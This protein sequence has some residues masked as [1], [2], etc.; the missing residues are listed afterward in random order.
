MTGAVARARTVLSRSGGWIDHAGPDG[1]YPVRLGPDRR[2]RTV[3]RLDERSFRAL[4]ETPGLR[5]RPGGG[6]TARPLPAPAEDVAPGAPGRISGERWLVDPDGATVPRGA[7]LG[8][9][10]I[11]WLAR[12]TSADGRP[13]LSPAQIAAGE[14]LRLDAELARRGHSITMRWDALPRASGG[15]LTRTEPGDRSLAASRRVSEALAACDSDT[16][17]FVNQICVR[18]Q[19]LQLAEQ[20]CG[21]RRRQGKLLLKRGLTALARHYRIG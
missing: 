3:L 9:S 20:A 17:G 15:S 2:S 5:A 16:R 19:A 8:E 18:S 21:L 4:I 14:R 10:P 1:G 13:W 6:W 7:N 12:R 11:A